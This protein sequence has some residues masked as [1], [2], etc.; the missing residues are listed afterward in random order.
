MRCEYGDLRGWQYNDD[1]DDDDEDEEK[2]GLDYIGKEW[3]VWLWELRREQVE[4]GGQS[5]ETF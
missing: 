4:R 3:R 1:E 5:E 2:W